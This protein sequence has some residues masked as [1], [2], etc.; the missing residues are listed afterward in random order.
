MFIHFFIEMRHFFNK[1]IITKLIT[2]SNLELDLHGW[3][4]NL[5]GQRKL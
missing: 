1:N 5:R 2:L 3:E 4:H